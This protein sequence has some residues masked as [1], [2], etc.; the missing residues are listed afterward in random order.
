MARPGSAASARLH[1]RY[2]QRDGV[3]RDGRPGRLYGSSGEVPAATLEQPRFHE[4]QQFRLIISPEDAG[5]LDLTHPLN[6][7]PLEG[8]RT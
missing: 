1:L 7:R 2:I 6:S 5:D 8:S 4:E 3:E